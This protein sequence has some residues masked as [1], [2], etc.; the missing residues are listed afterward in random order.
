MPGL[1]LRDLRSWSDRNP[2][3]RP[4]LKVSAGESPVPWRI[5]SAS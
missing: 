4:V 3:V 1:C 2:Y 5:V